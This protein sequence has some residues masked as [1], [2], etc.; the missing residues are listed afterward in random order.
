MRSLR[1]LALT[2]GITG[3]CYAQEARQLEAKGD[4]LAA[5]NTLEALVRRAPTDAVALS[6]FAEF[7]D[8]RSDPSARE[9]YEKLYD[10]LKSSGDQ[11]KIAQVARRL[12]VLDLLA[13]DQNS[14]VRHL[15]AY[16]SAGGADLADPPSVQP[17][18]SSTVE[19]R[20][21][22]EI[23]GPIRSFARMAALS[24][25]LATEDLLP[26]LGRN[27]VT[28]GYQAASSN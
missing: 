23:P 26:A 10:A 9:I 18:A 16:R 6:A 28:N 20:P 1:L 22:V 2:L 13:G 11:K 17:K 27:V 14:A 4:A 15:A 24:P 3:G 8:R 25:D 7:L 5:R 21:M 12:V 19:T